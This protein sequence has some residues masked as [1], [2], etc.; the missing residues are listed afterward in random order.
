MFISVRINYFQL[1][2][3]VFREARNLIIPIYSLLKGSSMCYFLLQSLQFK[4]V[5][6]NFRKQK[7]SQFWGISS[8][9]K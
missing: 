3:L 9:Q 2:I 1:G 5:K 7:F 8:T 6:I 4:C